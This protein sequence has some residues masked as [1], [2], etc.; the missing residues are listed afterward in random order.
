MNQRKNHFEL[1]VPRHRPYNYL[2]QSNQNNFLDIQYIGHHLNRNHSHKL[3]NIPDPLDKSSSRFLCLSTIHLSKI[4]IPHY[5]GK[6]HRIRHIPCICHQTSTYHRHN[7]VCK[8][9]IEGYFRHYKLNN[10]STNY[11]LNI[12]LHILYKHLIY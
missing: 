11:I 6:F 1:L 2:W 8:H 5:F 10:M 9:H 4:N 12:H 7:Q 3:I